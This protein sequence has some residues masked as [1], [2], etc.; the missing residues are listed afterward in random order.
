[1]PVR[2]DAVLLRIFIGE[3]ERHRHHPLYEAI[4]RAAREA[5]LAGAT[6]LRG[7]MGYGS[8]GRI[9]SAK[10]LDL[11]DDLPVVVEIVDAAARIEAFLPTLEAMIGSGLATTERVQVLRYGASDEA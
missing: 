2:H 1:M 5:G 4:V 8:S 11:S 3:R 9:E 10:I 6:V 7:M